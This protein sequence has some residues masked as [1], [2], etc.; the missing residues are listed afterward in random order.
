MYSG[1]HRRGWRGHGISGP[2]SRPLPPLPARTPRA[3]RTAPTFL[4]GD[5]VQHPVHGVGTVLTPPSPA[6]YM[7]NVRFDDA[8]TRVVD[9]L[10]LENVNSAI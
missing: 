10:E 5:R 7:V 6:S 9:G 3:K 2:P 4:A 8:G 1:K